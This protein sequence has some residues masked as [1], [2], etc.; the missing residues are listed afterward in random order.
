MLKV[1]NY[2]NIWQDFS[3]SPESIATQCTTY[4]EKKCTCNTYLSLLADKYSYHTKYFRLAQAENKRKSPRS[5][6]RK[7]KNANAKF[8]AK[9]PPKFLHFRAKI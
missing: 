6:K 7:F 9:T 4:L 5:Q 1:S 8:L 3:E 2:S